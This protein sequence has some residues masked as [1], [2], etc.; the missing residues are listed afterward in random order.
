[1]NKL[2]L[3]VKEMKANNE[4]EKISKHI[5]KTNFEEWTKR[6]IDEIIN[7]L[8]TQIFNYLKL[9]DLDIDIFSSFTS[10]SNVC[11]SDKP[12]IKRGEFTVEEYHN[13]K[14]Y[15]IEIFRLDL[16]IISHRSK[17]KFIKLLS[18]TLTHELTHL[19]QYLGNREFII[20][21]C[22]IE[23]KLLRLNDIENYKQLDSEKE[24]RQSG[25]EFVQNNRELILD[26]FNKYKD[27]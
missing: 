22:K 11:I 24:A 25:A 8:R 27:K 5:S 7:D 10:S 14:K 18:E 26:L 13:R 17:Y 20:S 4:D 2:L 1:M 19:R 12:I 21:Q 16:L 3:K 6:V 9:K 23:E 15:Y